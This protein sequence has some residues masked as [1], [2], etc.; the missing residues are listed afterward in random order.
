MSIVA[1]STRKRS[2][3]PMSYD[4]LTGQTSRNVAQAFEASGERAGRSAL[5]ASGEMLEPVQNPENLIQQ[6]GHLLQRA[7]AVQQTGDVAEEVP[8]QTRFRT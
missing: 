4:F 2:G 5:H 8:Q 3:E 6:V 7:T 1:P